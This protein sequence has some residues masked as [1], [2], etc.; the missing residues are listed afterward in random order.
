MSDGE[1]LEASA[2]GQGRL[3]GQGADERVAG[4]TVVLGLDTPTFS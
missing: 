3:G 1:I 2:N 4:R